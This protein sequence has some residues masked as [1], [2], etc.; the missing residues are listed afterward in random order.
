MTN[1]EALENLYISLGG[2]ESDLE[3]V[4]TTAEVIDLIKDVAGGGGSGGGGSLRVNYTVEGS[5]WILDRTFAE[6]RDAYFNGQNVYLYMPNEDPELWGILPLIGLG[7]TPT[8]QVHFDNDFT[9]G[10]Q[11]P[12]DYPTLNWD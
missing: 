7:I 1:L 10:G 11:S 3:G 4:N 9:F 12:D 6:I 8:Y 5:L 2:V